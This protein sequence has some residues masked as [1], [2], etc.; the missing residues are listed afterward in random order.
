MDRELKLLKEGFALRAVIPNVDDTKSVTV[1]AQQGLQAAILDMTVRDAATAKVYKVFPEGEPAFC[2]VGA[3]LGI[4]MTIQ[5][6]GTLAGAITR[7]VVDVDTQA[8]L[9][10]FTSTIAA[11]GTDFLPPATFTMPNKNLHLRVEAGH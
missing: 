11:G 8:E 4:S 9:W 3:L 6:V 5:N 2:T 1:T 10:S 7:R